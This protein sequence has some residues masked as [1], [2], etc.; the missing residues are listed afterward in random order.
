M[1]KIDRTKPVLVTGATGYIAG[2]IVKELLD[3]GFTVHAAIRDVPNKDKR[4]HLDRIAQESKGVIKYF[5]SDLLE[6]NSYEDSIIDCE[7]VI[8]TAS[9]F[10]LDSKDPQKELIDPALEGTRNVLNSVN[11]TNSVKRIII[12]SSVAA[13]YGD[14][15]ESKKVAGGIFNE[16]M[17]NETS[18]ATMGEYAYSKTIA[19]KEA[20]KMCHGQD[21]WDMV[22]I[23][24]S[25][26]IGPALN[27][28]KDFESK[29]FMLQIGNGDMKYGVP[30]IM[31]GMVDVRDV[32]NAHIR[33]GFD[34]KASG[35]YIISADSL[36]FLKMASYLL[37]R[38]GADYPI[39][40]RNA[41]KFLVWLIA[42]FIGVKREFI[43]RNVGF[44]VGFDNSRSIDELS[45][46]YRTIA[47]S[48]SE[49]F[50]QFIDER[51]ITS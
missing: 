17:W 46:E 42:P 15:I 4:A 13:I 11:Q 49:F 40:T 1:A 50:Q 34:E 47:D 19:E 16:T 10:F 41:P 31:T 2:W 7:L 20:W 9:P 23:N 48:A 32:A 37:D 22:A 28:V 6:T 51:F 12:T 33:A 25:F 39:P 3:E 27:P 45:M 35:R 38:Y 24:P 5:E 18:S 21:R 43:S 14:S 8:H 26:V 44:K 36:T 29:K 30:D